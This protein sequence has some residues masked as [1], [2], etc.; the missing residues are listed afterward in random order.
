MTR[1]DL[2][3][4][5]PYGTAQR[6]FDGT[7]W[8][9]ERRAESIRTEYAEGVLRDLETLRTRAKSDAG[10]A[11]VDAQ[12]ERYRQG[13]RTRFMAWLG[14]RHGLVSSF[15]AGPANFPVRQMEKK[16][17]SIDNHWAE[18]EGWRKRAQKAILRDIKAAEV[19]AQGGP[20]AVLRAKL[21]AEERLS[22][23]MK[24]ANTV[25]RSKRLSDEEKVAKLV[26]QGFSEARAR[27]LLE[28]DYAGRVGFPPFELSTCRARIK[29][30]QEAIA[31]EEVKEA[32]PQRVVIYDEDEFPALAEEEIQVQYDFED[33]RLRICWADRP[34]RATI[35]KLK[36]SGWRWSRQNAGWQRK[37]TEAAVMDARRLLGVDLPALAEVARAG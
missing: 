20:L 6:A 34:D 14:A 10:R 17:I 22:E 32:A 26:E 35:S 5:I 19:E 28:P 25:C 7:S 30:T 16:H 1:D 15:I 33:D 24:A 37:L 13:Y 2:I 11:V 3:A 27:S 12:A 31:R 23:R 18:L 36:G 9:P 4:D 29:S 8:T 21:A